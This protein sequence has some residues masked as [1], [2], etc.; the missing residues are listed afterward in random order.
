MEPIPTSKKGKFNK[1]VSSPIYY[2]IVRIVNNFIKIL[3]LLKKKGGFLFCHCEPPVREA[4]N[5]KRDCFLS[6][7]M[8]RWWCR[9]AP[10]CDNAEDRELEGVS[11]VMELY[12]LLTK[13]YNKCYNILQPM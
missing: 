4:R 9:F 11:N 12:K 5:L 7:V 10:R 8:T 2:G 13:H 3:D 1:Q 6:I